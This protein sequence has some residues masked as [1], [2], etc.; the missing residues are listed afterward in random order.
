MVR[1]L[2]DLRFAVRMLLRSPGYT[3]AAVL[4]LALAIGA[5]TAIFSTVNAVL[6]RPLPYPD[7]EQLVV[8]LETKPEFERLPLPYLNYLDYRAGQSSFSTF[9]AMSIQAL[10]LTGKGEPEKMLVESYTHDFLPMLGVEPL[11][12]RNFLPEEDAPGGAKVVLL[13]HGLWTRRYAADPA[14]VGARITLDG[15]E[16]T[17][18]GVLP[19]N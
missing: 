6:L 18:I 3:L 19:P 4:T 5:N 11:L 2:R 16:H 7:S 8:G 15:A 1:L 10:T 9:A 12:G 14:I 13:D 17:V